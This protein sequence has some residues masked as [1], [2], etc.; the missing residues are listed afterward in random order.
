MIAT[1][2][3]VAA[4]LVLGLLGTTWQ[5]VQKEAARR[6]YQAVLDSI[7]FTRE[8]LGVGREPTQ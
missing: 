7:R 2:A 6:E 1:V 4:S 3:V 5:A 8:E